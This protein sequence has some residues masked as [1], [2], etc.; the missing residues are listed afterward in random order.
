MSYEVRTDHQAAAYFRRLD[1][2]MKRRILAR[3]DEI[4]SDPHGSHSKI[5]ANAGGRR[6]SRVGDYRVVFAI[7]D[8]S[9]IVKVLLI[10]PRGRIYRDL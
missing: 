6:S 2:T 3:L 9:R 4:S 5:L 7:D 8:E 1:Q 10:G